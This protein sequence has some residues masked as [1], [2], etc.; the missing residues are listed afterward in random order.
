MEKEIIIYKIKSIKETL[1][2]L[3]DKN[4]LDNF[5]ESKNY[6][7]NKEIFLQYK[8]LKE[9]KFWS[10]FYAFFAGNYFENNSQQI[11]FRFK[12]FNEKNNEG[13]VW[14]CFVKSELQKE[15][16][17]YW[18]FPLYIKWKRKEI[19]TFAYRK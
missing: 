17:N 5:L 8:I 15:N 1:F 10:C 6:D 19:M 9:S 4:D 14:L 3:I 2:L 18:G 7:K 16:D 11:W 12:E 13:K